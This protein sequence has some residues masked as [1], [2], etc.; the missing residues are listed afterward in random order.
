MEKPGTLDHL[1]KWPGCTPRFFRISV[2]TKLNSAFNNSYHNSKKKN[3]YKKNVFFNGYIS[4]I[5]ISAILTKNAPKWR[6]SAVTRDEKCTKV[7]TM[8]L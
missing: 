3:K 4:S 5:G 7:Q 8:L 6:R 1:P 2:G